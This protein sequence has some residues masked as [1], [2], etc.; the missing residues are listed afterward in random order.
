MLHR[1]LVQIAA[2]APSVTGYYTLINLAMLGTIL[3]TLLLARC[4]SSMLL[5]DRKKMRFIFIYLL[6][7]HM[8][9]TTLSEQ[10]MTVNYTLFFQMAT[11][12][13]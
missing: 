2:A 10:I 11:R 7:Y 13:A 8:V 9:N 4:V 5:L 1:W 3:S 6:D 12:T